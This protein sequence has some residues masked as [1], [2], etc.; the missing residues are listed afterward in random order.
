MAELPVFARGA[1]DAAPVARTQVDD[2]NL[3]LARYRWTL[4][5]DGYVIRRA[6][7]KIIYLHR[8]VL[9]SQLRSG[10]V[11]DHINR[12]KLDN[13]LANLRPVTI[14]QNNQNHGAYRKNPLGLR[15]VRRCER[16]GK[17]RATVQLN[18][19]THLLGLFDDPLEAA[20]AASTMRAKIMPFTVE[21]P[22]GA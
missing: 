19:K 7:G 1:K 5:R 2:C 15:G 12:D 8:V 20:L 9:G 6:K 3:Y 16:T 22:G 14:A 11:C 4:A 17:Y 18:Y 10:L 21:A 13:R